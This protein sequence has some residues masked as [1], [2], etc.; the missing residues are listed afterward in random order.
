MSDL[1]VE[2]LKYTD[3]QQDMLLVAC[4]IIEAVRARDQGN[5]IPDKDFKKHLKRE[6]VSLQHHYFIQNL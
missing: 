2:Y 5:A 6:V 4:R 3:E 1:R